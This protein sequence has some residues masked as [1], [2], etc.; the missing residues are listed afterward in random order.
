MLGPTEKSR[1]LVTS[2]IAKWEIRFVENQEMRNLFAT[3]EI[4]P[5]DFPKGLIIIM[6]GYGA[7]NGGA[8]GVGGWT[9]LN[10]LVT[11]QSY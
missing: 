10:R 7:C 8:G 11:T 2:S 1:V 6:E 3:V 5:E 9:D 4:L